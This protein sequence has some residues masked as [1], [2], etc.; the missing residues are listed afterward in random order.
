MILAVDI[1]NTNIKL[2]G[3]EDDKLVFSVCVASNNRLTS[4]QYCVLFSDILSSKGVICSEI[5]SCA[6]SSVVPPLTDTVKSALKSLTGKK[7]LTVCTGTKTGLFIK[8]ENPSRLGSDFVCTAVGAMETV[9]PPCVVFD[10]GTAV[11]VTAVDSSK[12]LVGTAIMPGVSSSV[13]ALWQNTAQLPLISLEALDVLPLGK[14]TQDSMRAGTLY[15]AA[16]AVDG[17]FK[18]FCSI[19]GDETKLILTGGDARLISKYCESEF[20]LDEHIILKGLRKICL[21]NL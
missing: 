16:C 5:K 7:V 19:L 9:T 17:M 15:G 13:R 14:N 18:R 21:K 6:I 10:L 8:M 4:D 20:I 3:F 12:A 11:T 1:G 2:G